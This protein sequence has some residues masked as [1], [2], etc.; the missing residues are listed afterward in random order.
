MGLTFLHTAGATL[1][2][3]ES[4][5]AQAGHSVGEVTEQVSWNVD[6]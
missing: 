2:S 5:I 4:E 3:R 1:Y 6:I